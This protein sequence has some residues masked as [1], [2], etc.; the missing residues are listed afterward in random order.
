MLCCCTDVLKIILSRLLHAL[1]GCT[2]L[3]E[4]KWFLQIL[5]CQ[6]LP[7]K[8]KLKQIFDFHFKMCYH[9]HLIDRNLLCKIVLTQKRSHQLLSVLLWRWYSSGGGTLGA[10]Y[11]DCKHGNNIF[12]EEICLS[13]LNTK[14]LASLTLQAQRYIH[15][16]LEG[17]EYLKPLV[18]IEKTG[19]WH[20]IV[21]FT[22]FCSV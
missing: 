3:R 15:V 20:K 17:S 13:R 11:L 2:N 9:S 5:L 14:N 4:K 22:P 12:K 1:W 21:L 8:I 10:A 18:W 19:K 7:V 6:E 16:F